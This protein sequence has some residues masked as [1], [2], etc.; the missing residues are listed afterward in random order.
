LKAEETLFIDDNFDNIE[1][2]KTIGIQ[3]IWVN[4]LGSALEKLKEY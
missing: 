3:T 1:S 2:A 4:P